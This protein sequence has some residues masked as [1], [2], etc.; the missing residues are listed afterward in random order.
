M[1]N[2][3]LLNGSF[4]LSRPYL[5]KIIYF[6][7]FQIH[8]V[9]QGG[10]KTL[11]QKC[12]ALSMFPV[13][14]FFIMMVRL[15]RPWLIFRFGPIFSSRVGHFAGN[16]EVYLCERDA[17]INVPS[18]RSVDIFYYYS[19]ISNSQLKRMWDRKLHVSPID[20]F[21][22]DR[23]NR[24]VPG[25]R[26]HS[27]LMPHE[28]RDV[29]GLMAGTPPHLS[30]TSA[31]E[32]IGKDELKMLGIQEEAPFV[33]FHA[34]DSAYLR[35][36]S[37]FFDSDYHDYRD[38]N[39]NHYILA[40]E[41]LTK[42]GYYA[43]RMGSVVAETLNVTNPKIIDYASQS[44]RSDFMDIYLGAKCAF[45]ISSGTGIDAI[46]MIFRRLS[47]FVNLIPL[48]YGRFWQP[49]HLFIPKKYWLHSERRFMTF[50]EILQSGAGRFLSK[51]QFDQ[52]GIVLI[53]NTPEEIAAVAIEMDERLKGVW[54][55]TA[56]DEAL[57]RLFW[58]HF[59]PSELNGVFCARI[60]AEF[61]RQNSHLL[62]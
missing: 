27:I 53:E 36:T 62:K 34:R 3:C 40:A 54:Q 10:I 30:F 32:R 59:E 11:L 44:C 4:I 13:F 19:P 23:L 1:S 16:I 61:L 24:W 18:R 9:K 49:G 37:S 25:G 31:E 15:L 50:P 39:I 38:S 6:L 22:F 33:C 58:S 51:K 56:E 47:V 14:P 45:F 60:G 28:D 2:G 42:R 8:F 21:L 55:T 41:Q 35:K 17:G 7:R 48:E 46:P 29:H 26:V 57:Q 43:V 12:L 5:T 20:L 52:F